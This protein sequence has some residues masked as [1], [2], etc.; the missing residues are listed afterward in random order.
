MNPSRRLLLR[1][2][3]AMPGSVSI[4]F[5]WVGLFA[6]PT[7]GSSCSMSPAI[8]MHIISTRFFQQKYRIK[9]QFMSTYFPRHV[10]T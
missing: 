10:V 1:S 4:L 8:E 2:S 3:Y 7:N 9:A 5:V 6:T